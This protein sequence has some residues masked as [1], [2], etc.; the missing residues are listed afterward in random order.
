[1]RTANYPLTFKRLRCCH[2]RFLFDAQSHPAT[3]P[4]HDPVSVIT[5]P[6]DRWRER[7]G[8]NVNGSA[9]FL[10]R[11]MWDIASVKLWPVLSR[12]LSILAVVS[13]LIV[14]TAAPS[15]AMAAAPAG[16][17]DMASTSDGMPCCT[18]EK[19]AVPDCPKSCPLAALCMADCLPYAPVFGASYR[20][21][22]ASTS[23]N[24]SSS[25]APLRAVSSPL[26]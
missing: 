9:L 21:A 13:L 26:G 2:E 25:S 7:S 15:V 19:P 8:D 24:L 18:H 4:R 1:M 5:L 20:A 17:T 22:A 3:K 12:L 23:P 16:E 6:F 14:P 10:H 11:N